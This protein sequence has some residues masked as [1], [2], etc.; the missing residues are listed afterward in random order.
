MVV[1][2]IARAIDR[3]ATAQVRAPQRPSRRGSSETSISAAAIIIT[4]MPRRSGAVKPLGV[5]GAA[6]SGSVTVKV[7]PASGA[8][9]RCGARARSR[10]R[11]W[12]AWL[13]ES[14]LAGGLLR[15]HSP[16]VSAGGR[17]TREQPHG[18]GGAPAQRGARAS[19]RGTCSRTGGWP[20]LRQQQL[21]NNHLARSA[22]RPIDLG[23]RSADHRF[24]EKS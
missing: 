17:C 9:R 20:A 16:H 10:R 11:I 3:S 13:Y 19:A 15:F 5:P 12:L 7:A 1:P 14:H 18:V 8:A 21:A 6:G 22:K 2:A 4:D 23:L 24:N